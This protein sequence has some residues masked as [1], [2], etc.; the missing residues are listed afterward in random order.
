MYKRVTNGRS[1][2]HEAAEH[3]HCRLN[4]AI[5]SRETLFIVQVHRENI[6][7]LSFSARRVSVLVSVV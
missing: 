6:L 7:L 1:M 3:L 5:F 2:R 4:N